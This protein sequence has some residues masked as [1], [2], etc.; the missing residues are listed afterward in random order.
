[1]IKANISPLHEAIFRP[2]IRWLLK[3]QFHAIQVLGEVP[4][5]GERSTLLLPNHSTWWDG[6]FIHILKVQEFRRQTFLMMLEEQL[7]KNRFFSRV[8]AYS[9]DTQSFRGNLESIKY[10]RELLSSAENPVVCVF[11][12]GVLLP[13]SVRPLGYKRGTDFI[14]RK[15]EHPI[16]ICQLAVKCEYLE[17]QRADVFV[18]FGNCR[19]VEPGDRL[20]IASLEH[21]HEQLL[22]ELN[23][24]VIQGEKGRLVLRGKRSIND[25]F[26][27]FQK[28]LG[29]L[30]GES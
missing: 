4:D 12:Q 9:I 1:M 25:S 8:G 23:K 20:D 29:F 24:R 6:F 17:H 19:I 22:D 28:K 2:Y 10:T 26:E 5:F 3:K 13:W 14:T 15:L 11:P 27:A 30:R 21:E 18:Q 7:S 16:N